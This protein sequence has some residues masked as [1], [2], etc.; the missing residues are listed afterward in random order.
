MAAYTTIDGDV[1][2]VYTNG[3]LI[4]NGTD[5]KI[6]FKFGN[7]DTTTKDGGKA[8]QREYTDRE[9]MV[10][11]GFL[12]ADPTAPNGL[13]QL[14]ALAKAGT[15][16]VVKAGSVLTG[17]KYYQ[18]TMLVDSLDLSAS[19]KSNIAVSYSFVSDG[20]WTETTNP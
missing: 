9:W 4:A 7:R 17:Q 2:Q 15:K 18:G 19:Q 1:I 14:Q 12:Y 3:A 6:G 10:S 5:C 16:V 13:S 11:G 8:K 20:D